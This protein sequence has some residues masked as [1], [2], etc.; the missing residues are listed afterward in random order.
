MSHTRIWVDTAAMAE[1]LGIHPKTLL[2]LR[3]QLRSPFQE[4]THYRYGGL[5]TG[6]PLQWFPEPTDQA[7][8]DFKRLPVSA[9]ETFSALEAV[10]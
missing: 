1:R 8:T 10:A 9:V 2:R 3:K 7:F 6:A 4:G 5:T